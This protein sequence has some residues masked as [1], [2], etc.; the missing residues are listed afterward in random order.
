MLMAIAYFKKKIKAK[1][2]EFLDE[3]DAQRSAQR[4]KE[5]EREQ[6]RKEMVHPKNRVDYWK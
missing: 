4:A 6:A 3:I 1:H 2:Q 5:E